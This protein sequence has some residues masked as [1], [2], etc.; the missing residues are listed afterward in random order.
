M[1][2]DFIT[3]VW[4]MVLGFFLRQA[5]LGSLQ[6]VVIRQ[7]LEG[8]TISRFMT[9][10]LVTVP[11]GMSLQQFVDEII[12]HHRFNQYPVL[13]AEGRLAGMVS[14]RAPREVHP[15]SWP[16]TTV[17]E[18]MQPADQCVRLAPDDDAI[19]ALSALRKQ[20]NSRAVIVT[21]GR[22]VGIVSLRDLLAFLALKID[23]EPRQPSYR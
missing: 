21:E 3:G 5:A 19:D 12:F 11:A 4:F 10:D 16:Q 2:H 15:A 22:P 7:N 8:D 20:D 6:M 18:V 14:A 17:A 23:L 9:T 13:D 1:L